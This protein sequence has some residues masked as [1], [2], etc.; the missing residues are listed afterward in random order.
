MTAI[1]KY[2]SYMSIV[3][4][5]FAFSSC[6]VLLCSFG[7]NDYCVLMIESVL[8]SPE[9]ATVAVGETQQFTA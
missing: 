2:I 8:I 6:E 4:A 5:M 1:K 3:V 7:M 9:S